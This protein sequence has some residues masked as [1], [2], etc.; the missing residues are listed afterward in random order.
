GPS[1]CGKSTLMRAIVGVQQVA[2]GDV[3]VLGQPAG[4]PALRSRVG[5]VTQA[6]SVYSD[7]SVREN[8]DFF[9]RVLGA[10]ESAI[11]RALEAVSLGDFADRVAM[12]LSGGQFARLSLAVALLNEP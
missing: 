10:P 3:T 2:G 6:P 8:L 11:D 9:R 12:R 4:S 5:Y 7:L 1:G